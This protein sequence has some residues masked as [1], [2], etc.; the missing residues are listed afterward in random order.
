MLTEAQ[1]E[2]IIDELLQENKNLVQKSGREAFS[3][4]MGLA[5]KKLRGRANAEIVAQVLKKKLR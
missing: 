5:M 1:L 4:L 3:V 2:T